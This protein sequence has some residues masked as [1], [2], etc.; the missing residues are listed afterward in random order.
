MDY[1]AV[2][3]V[4]KDEDLT[5][6]PTTSTS[7]IMTALVLLAVSFVTHVENIDDPGSDHDTDPS[8]DSDSDGGL[9]GDDA[10]S[11]SVPHGNSSPNAY[12]HPVHPTTSTTSNNVTP[13]SFSTPLMVL[14]WSKLLPY[15]PALPLLMSR[16]FLVG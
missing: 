3:T 7:R 2:I 10:T 9:I 1:S 5:D 15:G 16:S 6:I 12:P 11:F 13:P 4:V 8:S 14:R